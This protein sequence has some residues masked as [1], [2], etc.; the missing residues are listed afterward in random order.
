MD[1]EEVFIVVLPW[2]LMA[3]ACISVIFIYSENFYTSIF[4]LFLSVG[5]IFVGF[6][7]LSHEK[8]NYT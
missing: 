6:L 7:V 4:W 5:Y 2:F 1:L 3:I 8:I